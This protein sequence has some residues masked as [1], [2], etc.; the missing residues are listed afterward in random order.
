MFVRILHYTIKS[1]IRLFC[2][3]DDADLGKVPNHDPLILNQ[4][5]YQLS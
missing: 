1:V 4:Q 3:V 2:Q 5:S